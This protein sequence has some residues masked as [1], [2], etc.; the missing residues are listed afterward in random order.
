MVRAHFSRPTGKSLMCRWGD[1]QM[2]QKNSRC[3]R[4]VLSEFLFERDISCKQRPQN[5][6]IIFW[7]HV[8]GIPPKHN[9]NC[10]KLIRLLPS[11]IIYTTEVIELWRKYPL[12]RCIRENKMCAR[13]RCRN[14]YDIILLYI[15]SAF[16]FSSH[17]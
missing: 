10:W 5:D 8:C 16:D 2:Q 6:T 12:Y 11:C 1:K 9:Y 14:L 4:S 17:E 13:E 7:K 3:F 15:G